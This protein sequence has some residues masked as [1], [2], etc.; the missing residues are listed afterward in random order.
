MNEVGLLC[1]A[2][3]KRATSAVCQNNITS[4]NLVNSLLHKPI[5]VRMFVYHL[6]L[7]R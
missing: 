6:A 2:K 5:L 3:R 1:L 4:F 7:V